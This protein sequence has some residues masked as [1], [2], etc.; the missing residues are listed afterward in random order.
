MYLVHFRE[1]VEK[2][3]VTGGFKLEVSGETNNM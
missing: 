3:K 2:R 1:G